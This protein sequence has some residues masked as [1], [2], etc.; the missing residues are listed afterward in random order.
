MEGGQLA[1]KIRTVLVVLI[2]LFFLFPFSCFLFGFDFSECVCCSGVRGC[3]LVGVRYA[4]CRLLLGLGG[5]IDPTL[6]LCS[7][8]CFRCTFNMLLKLS[9]PLFSGKWE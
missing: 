9:E 2:Y 4:L 5:Q 3:S 1:G 6:N 7:V 8:G